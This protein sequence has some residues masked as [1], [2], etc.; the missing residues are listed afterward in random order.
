MLDTDTEFRA[1]NRAT[2]ASSRM[3]PAKKN[4]YFPPLT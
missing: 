2:D 3:L 1:S 4:K